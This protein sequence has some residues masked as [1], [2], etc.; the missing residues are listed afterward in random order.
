MFDI[1][2]I[3]PPELSNQD[4][5][6]IKRTNKKTQLKNKIKLSTSIQKQS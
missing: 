4:F 1:Y 6:I 2:I 5:D 3:L